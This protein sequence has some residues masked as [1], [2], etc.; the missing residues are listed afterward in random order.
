MGDTV[1]HLGPRHGCAN[2][3]RK[4]HEG[5]TLIDID[6]VGIVGHERFLGKIGATH[7]CTPRFFH[8]PNRDVGPPCRDGGTH[9]PDD[10]Q[11]TNGPI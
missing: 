4:R 6:L 7:Y 3:H 10:I 1:N 2:I 8:A 9:C 11:C 5:A